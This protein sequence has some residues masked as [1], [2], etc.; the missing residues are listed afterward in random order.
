MFKMA[1]SLSDASDDSVR[2]EMELLEWKFGPELLSSSYNKIGRL[3][4][5]LN[6]NVHFC[7]HTELPHGSVVLVNVTYTA[8]RITISPAYADTSEGLL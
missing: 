2:E 6:G 8:Q 7:Q 3:P 4:E 1:K 5:L